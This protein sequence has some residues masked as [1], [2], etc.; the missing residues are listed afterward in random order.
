[1]SKTLLFQQWQNIFLSNSAF[2]HKI[3]YIIHQNGNRQGKLS[4][5]FSKTVTHEQYARKQNNNKVTTELF[6][7]RYYFLLGKPHVSTSHY[8]TWASQDIIWLHLDPH[9]S[10][11]NT[12]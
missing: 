11:Y 10:I 1:M 12:Y 8:I 7:N 5:N 6:G 4:K 2:I 9:I 3:E